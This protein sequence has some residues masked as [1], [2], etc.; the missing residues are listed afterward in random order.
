MYI[1]F[2]YLL[3]GIDRVMNYLFAAFIGITMIKVFHKLLP[4][5]DGII[6]E[7]NSYVK[8][9]ISQQGISISFRFTIIKKYSHQEGYA[10]K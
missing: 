4:S 7:K 9:I 2:A 8:N 10:D 3:C 1:L 6:G 5:Y